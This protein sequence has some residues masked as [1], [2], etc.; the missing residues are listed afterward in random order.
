ML[1]VGDSGISGVGNLAVSILAA[2]SLSLGE[3]GA[4]TT[5][6]FLA[7]LVVG[8]SKVLNMDP[9]TLQYSAKSGVDKDL[10]SR[11]SLGSSLWVSLIGGFVILVLALAVHQ[12]W[13]GA[14]AGAALSLPAL[15]LQDSARWTAYA[16]GSP[17]VAAANSLVW[18][19]A[20]IPLTVIVASTTKSPFWFAIAWGMPAFL[21]A[22][23]PFARLRV[24]PS[25]H[26]GK[27]WIWNQRAIST[28]TSADYLLTQATS[29]A[30]ALV[31][32]GVA[33]QAAL[34]LLRIAQ[35]PLTPLQAVQ[36]ATLA[37]L[38]PSAVRSVAAHH[39]RKSLRTC[40]LAALSSVGTVLCLELVV[41]VAPESI[42]TKLVGSSWPS[43]RILGPVIAAQF[44][45]AGVAAAYGPLLRALGL[46]SLQVRI[47][48]WATPVVV[49][50][51]IFGAEAGGALGGSIAMATGA[52]CLGLF[53][54]VCCRREIERRVES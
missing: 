25:L 44:I 32:G 50:L 28:R 27:C 1:A 47:K 35:L 37:L 39:W 40:H 24:T 4:L 5:A 9:F 10:A 19:A 43:A 29:Q 48:A 34:G 11:A 49:L 17:G 18:T 20:T 33:G 2:R 6:M 42:M 12:S 21:G 13:S 23:F 16:Y 36:S 22:V 45:A 8:L 53:A 30:G 26:L 14:L 3:F 41:F 51:I 52:L 54:A 7:I 31:I 38:Q 15:I 46:I